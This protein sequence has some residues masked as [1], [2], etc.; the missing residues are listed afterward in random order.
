[1]QPRSAR[2]TGWGAYAPEKVVTN[3]DMERLVETSDEWI[4]SRTGIRERRIAAPDESTATLAANAGARALAVSGIDPADVGLVLVAT[5]TPDYQM[6]STAA[7]VAEALGT[8]QAAAM[9]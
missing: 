1:M 3:H 4:V 8:R 2:I 7:L 5:C 6:P 9:D